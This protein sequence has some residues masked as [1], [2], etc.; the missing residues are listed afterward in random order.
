[1]ITHLGAKT[2]ID[3]GAES[4][5]TDAQRN[6]LYQSNNEAFQSRLNSWYAN[7][8]LHAIDTHSLQRLSMMATYTP[9][10][11]QTFGDAVTHASSVV[12]GTVTDLRTIPGS[13]GTPPQSFVTV[14]VDTRVK[15]V[16]STTIIVHQLGGIVPSLDW[17]TIQIEDADP[18]PILLPGDQAMLLLLPDA[19]VPGDFVVENYS[20]E[21]LVDTGGHISTVAGNPFS[22]QVDGMTLRGLTQAALQVTGPS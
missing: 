8:D 12:A 4:S 18:A 13:G 22:S 9:P 7:L 2:S 16:N 15:G 17:K 14:R 10:E 6:A 21:Y 3:N 19:L 11:S 20:G 1:V 5:L